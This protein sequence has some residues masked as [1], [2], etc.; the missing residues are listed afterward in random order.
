MKSSKPGPKAGRRAYE[1]LLKAWILGK[2]NGPNTLSEILNRGSHLL[3]Y[4]VICGHNHPLWML[5]LT[6][7]MML[8]QGGSW[9][10]QHME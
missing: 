2:G 4:D 10:V 9:K 7:N 1:E 3:H 8:P 6:R 5:F